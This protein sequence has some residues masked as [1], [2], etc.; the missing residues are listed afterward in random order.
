MRSRLRRRRGGSKPS[1]IEM[2]LHL[3]SAQ[4]IEARSFVASMPMFQGLDGEFV[5]MLAKGLEM[6]YFLPETVVFEKGSEGDDMFFVCE[7]SVDVLS[8]LDDPPVATR[9]K[10]TVFGEVRVLLFLL[11]RSVA[12]SLIRKGLQMAL[13]DN[14]TRNAHIRA[15]DSG[16]Q[17][18]ALSKPRLDEILRRFPGMSRCSLLLYNALLS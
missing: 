10:N 14:S 9:G 7:G 18:Y 8:D 17:C 6:R 15:R 5:N 12:V 2:P 16:V 4:E 1:A 13:L 11:L 3:L